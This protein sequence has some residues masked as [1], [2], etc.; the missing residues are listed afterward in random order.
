MRVCHTY[1]AEVNEHMIAVNQVLGYRPSA[2]PGEFE[3]RLA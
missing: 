2:R 1:N 3:K